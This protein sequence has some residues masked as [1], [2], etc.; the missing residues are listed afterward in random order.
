MLAYRKIGKHFFVKKSIR[1]MAEV[2]Y[3]ETIT[4]KTF[5]RRRYE[6]INL[7]R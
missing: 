5:L 1:I 2:C 6:R 3:N 7:C 4:L